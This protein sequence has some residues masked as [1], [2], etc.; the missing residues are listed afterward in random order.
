[1]AS[2][3]FFFCECVLLLLLLLFTYTLLLWEKKKQFEGFAQS[4]FLLLP[5]LRGKA[6]KKKEKGTLYDLT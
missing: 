3:F 4:F 5:R 2:F 6:K 1:M